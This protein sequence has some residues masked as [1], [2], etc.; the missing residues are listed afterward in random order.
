MER[1]PGAELFKHMVVD[2]EH[3]VLLCPFVDKVKTSS[4]KRGLSWVA[5]NSLR[6]NEMGQ[7]Y[8][9]DAGSPGNGSTVAEPADGA[10]AKNYTEE[11]V[12]YI[13]NNYLKIMFSDHPYE[14]LAAV[15]N[16]KFTNRSDET[17]VTLGRTIIRMSRPGAKWKEVTDSEVLF[18]EFIQFVLKKKGTIEDFMI[19]YD[20]CNV[21]DISW[22]YIGKTQTFPRDFAH[23]NAAAHGDDV[24]TETIKKDVDNW[25][26][27]A[28]EDHLRKRYYNVT[29]YEMLRLYDDFSLDMYLFN[30]SW[31]FEFNLT[32]I[33][34]D[35]TKDGIYA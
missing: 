21:C 18:H 16:H 27:A 19:Y 20:M 8:L 4:F 30:Y 1:P 6:V 11:E 34:K 28:V 35:P 31:P 12:D 24:D 2:H 32:L 9:G 10:P 13:L 15:Y 26:D 25:T 3:H 22:D 17:G 23:I 5:R 14:R 29:E 7:G 33:N